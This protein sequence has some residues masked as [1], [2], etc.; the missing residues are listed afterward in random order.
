MQFL[1]HGLR[2]AFPVEQG[3]LLVASPRPTL[4]SH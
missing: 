1:E 2:Y 3:A 4:P